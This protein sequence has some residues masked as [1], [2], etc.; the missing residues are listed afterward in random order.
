MGEG[1]QHKLLAEFD[2][3]PLVRRGVSI[4]MAS[5]AS[6]VIVVTGHRRAE[7]EASLGELGCRA[8]RQRRLCI[9]HRRFAYRRMRLHTR[10]AQM[11]SSLCLQTCPASRPPTSTGRSIP[12]RRRT[13]A[14]CRYRQEC[15]CGCRYARGNHCRGWR[16]GRSVLITSNSEL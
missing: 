5:G 10:N 8:D 14:R 13:D 4:A 12:S 11:V 3:M 2:G 15:A 7:I 9:R 16:F 1:G 6:A